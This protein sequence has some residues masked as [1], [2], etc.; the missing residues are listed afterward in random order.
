MVLRA[1]F[2]L[3]AQGSLLE[4]DAQGTIVSEIVPKWAV[5][6]VSEWFFQS[7]IVIAV[8]VLGLCAQGLD[9]VVLWDPYAVP[10][11][12]LAKNVWKCYSNYHI[13]K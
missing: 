10:V 3:C 9:Q 4:I 1:S 11:I 6:K 8:V 13:N 2:R 5:H 12:K 7:S